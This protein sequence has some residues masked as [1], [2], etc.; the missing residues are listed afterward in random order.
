MKS[1]TPP[2]HYRPDIDGLRAI[3]VLLVVCYHYFHVRGGYVGVDIF[4][5][6]SG[7]LISYQIFS[8]LDTRSFRLPVFYAKRIRRIFP[9]LVLMIVVTLLAGWYLLLPTDFRSLGK[10][11]AAGIAN[12]DNLLLWTEAGYFD[13]PSGHKPFLHLWSLGIEEQF[14]LTWPLALIFMYKAGKARLPI[15]IGLTLLSFVLNLIATVLD[16]NTAF[17][18]P[19]TRFWE[20]AAGG[21][22][23]YCTL[24]HPRTLQGIFG[25]QVSAWF[26]KYAFQLGLFLILLFWSIRNPLSQA[27]GHSCL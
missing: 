17:Y 10:H 7:F 20:L 24:H 18:M 26:V 27:I 14:Y 2:N 3:A 15:L 13:A 9:P 8:D 23:A 12:I 21:I 19:F 16:Q 5:V 1:M 6:I 11:A 25:R 4:F 22:L